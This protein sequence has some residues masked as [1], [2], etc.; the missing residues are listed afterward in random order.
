MKHAFQIFPKCSN[1]YHCFLLVLFRPT[2]WMG[3]GLRWVL[4][5]YLKKQK[6]LSFCCHVCRCVNVNVWVSGCEWVRARAVCVCVTLQQT[7]P[8]RHAMII[9]Q[10][11]VTETSSYRGLANWK[12][13]RHPQH[14]V[15]LQQKSPLEHA[16]VI[17]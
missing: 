7:N 3:S 10:H 15:I 11:S 4:R 6:M 2:G 5:S 9:P 17:P 13:P 12:M 14:K 1:Q 16:A 8:L